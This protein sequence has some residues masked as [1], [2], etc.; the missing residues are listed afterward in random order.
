MISVELTE[1]VASCARR[2]LL[3]MPVTSGS[4]ETERQR[5][6]WRRNAKRWRS[7]NRERYRALVRE[8]VRRWRKRSKEDKP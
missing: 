5:E 2:G 7:E 6:I 3:R 1:L 4:A 8:R